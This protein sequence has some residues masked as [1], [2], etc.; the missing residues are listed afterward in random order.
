ML[1]K[2]LD[3]DGY[4]DLLV[5]FFCRDKS[6]AIEG[7]INIH[8]KLIN[9]ISTYDFKSPLKVENLSNALMHLKKQMSFHELM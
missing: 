1:I 7:D 9:E 4:I 3:L 6:V 5:S 8:F 2:K